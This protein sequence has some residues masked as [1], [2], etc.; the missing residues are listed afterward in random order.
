MA[1]LIVELKKLSKLDVKLCI[2]GQH[3][4]MLDQVL[5]L[6]NLTPDF[7][8]EVMRKGQDLTDITIAVLNGMRDVFRLYKPDR[9]LV[10]GDTTTTLSASLASFYAGVKVGHVEAGLR[11]G[12]MLSPWPEEA[13]RQMTSVLADRHYAPTN[14]ARDNLL[15]ENV[16]ADQIIV[17]GNTVI[18]ALLLVSSSLAGNDS[19]M[20]S[21]A[22]QF[23]FL[24]PNKKL[25]LVTGHRRENFGDSFESICIALA[26]LASRSDVQI[27][28]P[29]HMN[30]NVREPV[31][32]HLRGL[33]NVFLLEPLEYL[34]F[35]HLMNISYLIISDSGGIQEE[36]PALGKPVLLMRETTERPEAVESGTVRL[37]GTNTEKI[38]NAAIL[39]IDN[40]EEYRRMSIAT[41]PYGTGTSCKTIG[42]DLCGG[43]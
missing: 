6:F 39:L 8:L 31:S 30:P 43:R 32:R 24:D 11:T 14:Q 28:Y 42:E 10:H 16:S 23:Y 2:T 27:V 41:N 15:A 5:A 35:V 3:R 22:Q 18:D 33:E 12:N 29:V 17:T 1:P 37:V 13:N 36:A 7:D 25:I 20:S 40:E 38:V 21:L 9:V 4:E 26:K 19:A 34:P